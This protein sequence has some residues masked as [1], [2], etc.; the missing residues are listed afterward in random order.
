MKSIPIIMVAMI[1]WSTIAFAQ[2]PSNDGQNKQPVPL[3][4]NSILLNAARTSKI[5]GAK[6]YKGDT[7]IGDIN[8]VLVDLANAK[9]SAVILSVG[10]FLGLGDKLVAVPANKI[11][12]DN[13]ARFTSDLTK[14][15]LNNAPAFHYGK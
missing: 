3:V 14:D 9:I 7:S 8:D 6:V 4:D 1:G 13:E 11:K 10:G 15:D 2:Q 5:V 12:V